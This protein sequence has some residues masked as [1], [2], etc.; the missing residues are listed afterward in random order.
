MKMLSFDR[1]IIHF[2]LENA[3]LRQILEARSSSDINTGHSLLPKAEDGQDEDLGR[4]KEEKLWIFFFPLCK[5]RVFFFSAPRKARILA[6]S[7]PCLHPMNNLGLLLQRLGFCPKI[8]SG[9][10][11][12]FFLVTARVFVLVLYVLF[13]WFL[14][15]FLFV[16]YFFPSRR[17][18]FFISVRF[19]NQKLRCPFQIQV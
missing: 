19:F 12:Y 15:L 4:P 1:K 6:Q 7:F 8:A 3:R 18:F 14:F 16:L 11:L 10:F 17:V 9:N 2:R 5:S 13:S